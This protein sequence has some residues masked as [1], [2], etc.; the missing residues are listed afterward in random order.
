MVADTGKPPSI[1]TCP[2]FS[3]SQVPFSLSRINSY[4]IL[5]IVNVL[6]ILNIMEIAYNKMC[7]TPG[8]RLLGPTVEGAQGRYLSNGIK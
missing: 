8:L 5:L 3:H 1:Y 7:A 6:I 2:W 4:I